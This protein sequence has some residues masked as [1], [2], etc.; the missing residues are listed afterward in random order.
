MLTDEWLT[1]RWIL[2]RLGEFD[3]DR[4][5]PA[6][7]PWDT[8][9]EHYSLPTDGLTQPWKGRIWLNPPFGLEAAR[10]LAKMAYHGNGIA[11][12]AARTETRAFIQ[13]V[14]NIA[15]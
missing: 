5:G 12:I 4:C 9:R 15:D 6:I 8:A 1:P 7:R 10:W 13:Y 2:D 11:L 3:V 14:W